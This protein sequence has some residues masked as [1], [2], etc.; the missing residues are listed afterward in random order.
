MHE[1]KSNQQLT[2]KLQLLDHWNGFESD[3]C[4]SVI[5]FTGRQYSSAMQALY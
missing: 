4:V 1:L 5:V 2:T 3:V